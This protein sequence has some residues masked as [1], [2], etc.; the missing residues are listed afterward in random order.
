MK[1]RGHCSYSEYKIQGPTNERNSDCASY[2]L[3]S[4]YWTKVLGIDLKTAV[5][6]LS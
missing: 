4:I 3:Y 1:T 5:L 6:N 2:R